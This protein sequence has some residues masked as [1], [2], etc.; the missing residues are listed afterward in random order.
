MSKHYFDFAILGLILGIFLIL[1]SSEVRLIRI[2]RD[3]K[4]INQYLE[5]SLP[6]WDDQSLK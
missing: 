4:N 2:E 1:L 3:I 6:D 5:P